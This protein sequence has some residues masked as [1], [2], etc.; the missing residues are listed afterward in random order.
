MCTAALFCQSI[1]VCFGTKISAFLYL[2]PILRRFI[3]LNEWKMLW[4][5]VDKRQVWRQSLVVNTLIKIS[6]V[7]PFCSG[8]AGSA[9][10][11]FLQGY[12]DA[13]SHTSILK[14]T[15]IHSPAGTNVT[16]LSLYCA[17]LTQQSNSKKNLKIH[18]LAMSPTIKTNIV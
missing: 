17:I 7:N 4:K 6:L 11:P 9:D 3:K 12:S 10:R 8:C 18:G 2:L 14:V 1:T 16:Q 15:Y 13:T 5:A